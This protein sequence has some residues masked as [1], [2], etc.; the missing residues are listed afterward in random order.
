MLWTF[1]AGYVQ[2]Y[3]YV[4]LWFH[5]SGIY[6]VQADLGWFIP[7]HL[8]CVLPRGLT[9][10][11]VVPLLPRMEKL[12]VFWRE[13][14]DTQRTSML[15]VW[16]LL[17]VGV[18]AFL[19]AFFAPQVMTNNIAFGI[20]LAYMIAMGIWFLYDAANMEGRFGGAGSV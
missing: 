12:G 11:V 10:L 3:P 16:V 18:P 1:V 6:T 2:W 15:P 5:T 9:P 7:G 8:C 14:F 20:C 17:I 13:R 19:V 4:Q